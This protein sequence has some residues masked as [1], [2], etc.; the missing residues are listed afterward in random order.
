MKRAKDVRTQLTGLMERAEVPLI[1]NAD[2]GDDLPIRKA[3]TA[4]F[5]YNTARLQKSGDSYRTVKHTQTVMIHP[6]SCLYPKVTKE[7]TEDGKTIYIREQGI[8]LPKWVLYH[9]LVFT[10]REF[11]RQVIEIQPEWLI[12]VAPHYYTQKDIEADVRKMPKN[13]KQ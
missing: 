12:E 10:S 2:P 11:M 1:S 5:F 8:T 9:E 13:I 4:G 3:I 6:S 7:E